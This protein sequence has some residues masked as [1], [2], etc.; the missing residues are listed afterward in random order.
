[1]TATGHFDIDRSS[2]SATVGGSRGSLGNELHH[3]LL[4]ITIGQFLIRLIEIKESKIETYL[5]LLS[6]IT[7][8]FTLIFHIWANI[9]SMGLQVLFIYRHGL[10]Y[11]REKGPGE[12]AMWRLCLLLDIE[13]TLASYEPHER[14]P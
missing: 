8:D 2:K 12:F 14:R 4:Y 3:S 9:I 11:I 6:Y 7:R 10:L 5:S 1:M 13:W